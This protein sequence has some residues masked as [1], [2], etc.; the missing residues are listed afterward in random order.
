MATVETFTS[1]GSA[2]WTAPA[3]VH[4]ALVECWG[5]GGN[6]Q[7]GGGSPS[8]GANTSG[9]GGGGY[10]ASVLAVSPGTA[11]SYVV[12]GAAADSN[13]NSNTV[14]AKGGLSGAGNIAKLGGQASAGIGDVKFSGGTSGTCTGGS[15]EGGAGG[16][17]AGP[18]G[19]GITGGNSN[20]NGGGGANNSGGGNGGA[21]GGGAGGGE[22]FGGTGA[23]G[24]VRV[25]YT[26]GPKTI[27]GLSSYKSVNGLS[28]T[29]LKTVNG[30]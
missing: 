13:F 6:G 27:N 25:T 5:G 29:N 7:D 8:G 9:G 23:R 15:Q 14:L 30:L 20:A 22:D 28:T 21:P 12:G 10:S 26:V 11:Y 18:D 4:A 16:G 19:D 3:G 24:Q 17:A 1:V 2:S